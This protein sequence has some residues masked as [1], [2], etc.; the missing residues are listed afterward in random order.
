MLTKDKHKLRY[1]KVTIQ[2]FRLNNLLRL[3]K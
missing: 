3:L 2:V 1:Q